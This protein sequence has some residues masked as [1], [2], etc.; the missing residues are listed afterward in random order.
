MDDD[1][2]EDEDDEV[3]EMILNEILEIVETHEIPEIQVLKVEKNDMDQ[4]Q[5]KISHEEEWKIWMRS[6]HICGLMIC[7]S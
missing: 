1:E 2:Y 4:R 5:V 6:S 3:H 7:E